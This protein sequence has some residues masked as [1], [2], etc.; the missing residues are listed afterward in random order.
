MYNKVFN[1]SLLKKLWALGHYDKSRNILAT[2]TALNFSG[3]LSR[4]R[5][6][7]LTNHSARSNWEIYISSP[8]EALLLVSTKKRDLWEGP[9]PEVR[10]SRTSRHFA[11]AQSQVWQIWLA[12]NTKRLLWAC[13]EN[14]TFPEVAIL[15]AD[16]RER[17]LW[18]RDVYLSV[19]TRAVTGQFSGPYSTVRPAKI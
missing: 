13:S 14:C 16:Q 8:E 2:K 17:F 18:G 19:T 6:T 12:E 3:P 11:H 1:F 4:V 15:G 9:T 10:N 7:K 5:P